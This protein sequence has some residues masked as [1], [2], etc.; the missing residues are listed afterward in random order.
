MHITI[1]QPPKI[2]CD[3]VGVTYVCSY[4][5]LHSRMKHISMGCHFVREQVQAKK[6]PIS[7]V[8]TKDK[9][10]P[11]HKTITNT[12]FSKTYEQDECLWRYTHLEGLYWTT[13]KTWNPSP[14]QWS[15]WPNHKD[16]LYHYVHISCCTIQLLI[17]SILLILFI[18]II[19]LHHLFS[20]IDAYFI[21]E[22]VDFLGSR[23]IT[24]F[25]QGC[26]DPYYYKKNLW[27]FSQPIPMLSARTNFSKDLPWE[28]RSGW[29]D[30]DIETNQPRKHSKVEQTRGRRKNV[31]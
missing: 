23:S 16:I 20:L 31:M 15:C 26:L 11:S 5:I 30:G 17:W 10:R 25:R 19:I 27:K 4:T 12:T 22:S 29:P 24:Y 2:L 9:L 14:L 28:G 21:F 6:L 7:H 3:N 1:S 13:T 18:V 8:T